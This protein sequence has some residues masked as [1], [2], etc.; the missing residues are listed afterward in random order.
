MS[1]VT[2]E[3]RGAVRH[4]VLNRPEKRNALNDELIPGLG[5]A[6]P[7]AADDPTSTCVVLRGE[8]PMF[9]SR[10]G[11]RRAGRAGRRARQPARLP[12]R[13]SSR[14][15]TCSRR[16]P[17]RRSARST[18]ACIGGAMELALACDLRVMAADAMIGMPE[19]RVGLIPDV[20]GSSRLPAIVGLGRAKELIMTSQADRRDR[21]RAH[22]PRQPRRAGRR[23]R[24]RHRRARRR[25]AGLR[26]GRRGLRQARAG[27]GGQARARGDA[28]AG[29][30]R[31]RSCA[32]A[33]EDFARGRAGVR[34]EAPAGVQRALRAPSTAAAS[35]P[36]SHARARR[37]GACRLR[38]PPR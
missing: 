32:R 27:R 24:R 4:V 37:G 15:G 38:R 25:A 22:R 36:R 31:P 9:S 10:H 1:I 16:W 8:G 26:A 12:P 30:H 33:A 11:L 19:T 17:S 5:E 29:G 7:A 3:D 6:L 28:R 18:A 21:G 35:R 14:P 2:T 20:G 23:A 13:R 34:R